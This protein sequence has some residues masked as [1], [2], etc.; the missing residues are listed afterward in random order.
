SAFHLLALHSFPTRRSSDLQRSRVGYHDE[1]EV[2]QSVLLVVTVPLPEIP[3][4]QRN[5]K[6]V[7]SQSTAIRS[8]PAREGIEGRRPPSSEERSEEHT[9]ELQS[10]DHLVCRL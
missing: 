1:L 5:D 3:A 10:P 2:R 6:G 4:G 8:S 7:R 9:S